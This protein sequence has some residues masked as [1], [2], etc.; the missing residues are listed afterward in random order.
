MK[1]WVD[2]KKKIWILILKSKFWATLLAVWISKISHVISFNCIWKLNGVVSCYML[3]LA[4]HHLFDFIACVWFLS[5][6]SFFFSFFCEFTRWGIEGSLKIL[7]INQ[8][9]CSY[10]PKWSF[11]GWV[12]TPSFSNWSNWLGWA[13]W[14]RFSLGKIV[15]T[16]YLHLPPQVC[17]RVSPWIFNFSISIIVFSS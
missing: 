3:L 1:S 6:F 2:K 9:S 5:I 14:T 16:Y 11:K 15:V 7:I 4:F 12:A 13:T 17:C 8:W 10:V